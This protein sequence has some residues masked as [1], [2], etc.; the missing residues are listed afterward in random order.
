MTIRCEKHTQRTGEHGS[1]GALRYVAKLARIG[2]VGLLGAATS[3]CLATPMETRATGN[4]NIDVSMLFEHDG[5]RVYRFVD[6]ARAVYYTDCRG[7]TAWEESCGRNCS[8][9]VTVST[10]R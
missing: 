3:N 2:L 6:G 8:F 4:P 1:N 5:C 9:P 7:A 10:A